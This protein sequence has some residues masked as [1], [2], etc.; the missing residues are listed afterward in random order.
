M[1]TWNALGT[2]AGA[3]MVVH[4]WHAL[5]KRIW[6]P[7]ASPLGILGM[8][9]ALE[10]CYGQATTSWSPAHALLWTGNGLVVA[11]A[12]MGSVAARQQVARAPAEPTRPNHTQ[13]GS[14]PS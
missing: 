7:L 12:A 9:E 5:A 4:A 13:R 11:A 1:L 10:W 8:A 2:V 3:V 6:P 14:P